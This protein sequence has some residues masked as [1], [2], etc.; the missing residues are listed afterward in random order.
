MPEKV[1]A[2][3]YTS[4]TQATDFITYA[5]YLVNEPTA[6]FWNDTEMLRWLN[7]GILNIVARTWCLGAKETITLANDTLEYAFSNDYISVVTV[8]VTNDDDEVK[9]LLQ[10]HPSMVGHVPDPGE[11]VYYYEWDGNIGLYP[12][13]ADVSS[14]TCSVYQVPVPSVLGTADNSPLPSWFDEVLVNFVIAKA[15]F[16][17]NELGTAQVTMQQYEQQLQQYTR[18]FNM[19]QPDRF[20]DPKAK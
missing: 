8:H 3:Q 16:K 13:M 18:D 19:R 6:S 15:L 11:I 12:T 14:Y 1:A 2:S 7:E 5:R 10:G 20:N 4:S 9:A 17:D